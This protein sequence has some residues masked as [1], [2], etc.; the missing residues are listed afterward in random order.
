MA[1]M[2]R[3]DIK[4][5]AHFHFTGVRTIPKGFGKVNRGHNEFAQTGTAGHPKAPAGAGASVGRHHRWQPSGSPPAMPTCTDKNYDPWASPPFLKDSKRYEMN[6]NN[7][8]VMHTGARWGHYGTHDMYLSTDAH[9]VITQ[10]SA[11]RV[12]EVRKGYE[13][14]PPDL[15]RHACL[16]LLRGATHLPGA[17]RLLRQRSPAVS[18]RSRGTGWKR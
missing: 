3:F 17:S 13:S 14:T 7:S 18:R 8:E 4:P 2:V 11:R 1:M 10:I 9:L 16:T 15:E 6:R 5:D 12:D